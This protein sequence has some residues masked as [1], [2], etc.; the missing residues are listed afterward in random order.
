MDVVLI[1]YGVSLLLMA[2]GK[3]CSDS[4]WR[5]GKVA[6]WFGV[7]GF[8]LSLALHGLVAMLSVWLPG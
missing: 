8:L 3:F 7:V 4:G 1:C 2:G 5:L 6:E